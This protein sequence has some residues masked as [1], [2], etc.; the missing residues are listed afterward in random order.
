MRSLFQTIYREQAHRLASLNGSAIHSVALVCLA[1]A[2]VG[3][4]YGAIASAAG[5]PWWYVLLQSSL[6]FGGG[7]Q[8][9]LMG[10]LLAGGGWVAAVLAGLTLNSRLLLYSSAVS[11]LLQGPR[12]QR[13]LGAH[14]VTDESVAIALQQPTPA[15]QRLG[16]W[17]CGLALY[18]SWN[19]ACLLGVAL[20]NALG[21]SQRWGLDAAFPSLMLALV[22]AV[23]RPQRAAQPH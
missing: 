3:L 21:D 13:W 1:C 10:V 2:L 11:P 8:F 14:W 7:A 22:I 16:F 18:V 23:L 4:S 20:G 17:L 9:A 6:A 12:W 15:Q 19:M 5:L